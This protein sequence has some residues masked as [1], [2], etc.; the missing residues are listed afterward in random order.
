MGTRETTT[1]S[2]MSMACEEGGS[3][4]KIAI[5]CLLCM[6]GVPYLMWIIWGG[7]ILNDVSDMKDSPYCDADTR[8]WWQAAGFFFQ[9]WFW[10]TLAIRYFHAKTQDSSSSV[11]ELM[12]C[13]RLLDQIIVGLNNLFFLGWSIYA[14]VL[15]LALGDSPSID[16]FTGNCEDFFNLASETE[17]F[18]VLAEVTVAVYLIQLIGNCLTACTRKMQ[19]QSITGSETKEI[20]MSMQ[21]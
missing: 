15:L 11:L 6:V 17:S 9:A 2:L 18:L 7:I 21:H 20:G 8:W 14:I 3:T 12:A 4:F 13:P 19:G 1:M 5:C 16:G 10:V